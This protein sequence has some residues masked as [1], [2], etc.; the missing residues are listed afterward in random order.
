MKTSESTKAP[1]LIYLA[2]KFEQR[3]LFCLGFGWSLKAYITPDD[4]FDR[5]HSKMRN[6]N[7]YIPASLSPLPINA[8]KSLFSIT[9]FHSHLHFLHINFNDKC[10]HTS[11]QRHP[12]L[13]LLFG[14]AVATY[15][16]HSIHLADCKC[17]CWCRSIGD[18]AVCCNRT[19]QMLFIEL[20][21]KSHGSTS[22]N[23]SICIFLISLFMWTV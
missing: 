14:I 6:S 11:E 5:R 13:F 10:S 17:S 4:R 21:Q 15:A 20:T 3:V 16:N 7:N 23:K 18:M 8:I 22:D 1:D 12:L 2:E 9:K 19:P